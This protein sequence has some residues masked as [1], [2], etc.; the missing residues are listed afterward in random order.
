[1]VSH[2]GTTF[3]FIIL[4]RILK[5][6]RE[7][8]CDTSV[9]EQKDI[10]YLDTLLFSRRLLLNQDYFKQTTLCKRFGIEVIVA[11]RALADVESLEHLY[12]KLI[13]LYKGNT[14]I[15]SLLRYI[16]LSE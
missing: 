14:D 5:E 11:H 8:G 4:R 6:L 10:F 2:N 12:K 16:H 1:V 9:W 15:D 3:D 13:S 7:G